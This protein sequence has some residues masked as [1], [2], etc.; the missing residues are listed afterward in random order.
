MFAKITSSSQVNNFALEIKKKLI[1]CTHTPTKT[2]FHLK[3]SNFKI[4]FL[5]FPQL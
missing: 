3:F 2:N 4:I 1:I 5:Y